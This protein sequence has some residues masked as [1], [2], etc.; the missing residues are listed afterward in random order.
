MIRTKSIHGGLSGIEMTDTEFDFGNGITIRKTYA[1]L[2]SPFVL[3]LKPP[4]KYKHHDGPWKAA[5]GGVSF[6][7][8][9]E[10]EVPFIDGSKKSFD[11]LE[12]LWTIVSLLRLVKYPYISIPAISDISFNKML[13][14]EADPVVNPHE[15]KPRIFGPPNSQKPKLSTDV[16][17]WVKENLDTTMSLMKTDSKF[18]SAYKAFDSATEIGKSSAGLL[19]L[20]GAIEQLF[21]P[22]TGELKYRVSANLASFLSAHGEER[23]KLFKEI[24]NLYNDRS[25]A[26][27]TAKELDHSPLIATW[28][29]LRNALIKI[30]EDGKVPTQTDLEKL[31]F[32]V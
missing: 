18:Y 5:K 4:G 20:W 12:L 8:F 14:S 25:T 23:L 30:I 27:H 10:I 19:T 29:H 2:T 13:I 21:S 7:I 9:A 15:T 17:E 3:A 26:A 16:L 11:Q 31:I 24:S 28:V 22:S 1:H 32:N 6:D